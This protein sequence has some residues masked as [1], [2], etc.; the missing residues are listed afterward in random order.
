[1]ILFFFDRSIDLTS[2]HTSNRADESR[3]F[4]Y[5]RIPIVSVGRL[6]VKYVIR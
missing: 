2:F 5:N 1:V 6:E 4:G 3:V